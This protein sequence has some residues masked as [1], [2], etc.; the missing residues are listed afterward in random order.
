MENQTAIDVAKYMQD[1]PFGARKYLTFS[2]PSQIAH[3]KYLRS[4]WWKSRAAAYRR[5]RSF[6]CEVCG[7][8]GW[9]VHHRHYD[10]KGAER[11]CDLMLVCD[12]CHKREHGL[13]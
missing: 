3:E 9:Q 10:T 5:T 2:S 7:G 11:D 4:D 13:T 12:G 1:M 6:I 8:R